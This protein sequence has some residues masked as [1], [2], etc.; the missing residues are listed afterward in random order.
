MYYEHVLNSVGAL[1]VLLTHVAIQVVY[2]HYML[3]PCLECL[4]YVKFWHLCLKQ[5]DHLIE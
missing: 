4:R 5:E 2:C 3:T 1:L